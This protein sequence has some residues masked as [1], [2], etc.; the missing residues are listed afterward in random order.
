MDNRA[1]EK[2]GG[3]SEAT[4]QFQSCMPPW[5]IGVQQG[6]ADDHVVESGGCEEEPGL[7]A[8]RQDSNATCMPP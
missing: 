8:G 2:R 1:R 5:T 7:K 4:S 3:S 6:G